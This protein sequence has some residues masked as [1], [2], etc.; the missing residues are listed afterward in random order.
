MKGVSLKGT[1]TKNKL[2][3]FSCVAIVIIVSIVL[4]Y[5][6]NLKFNELAIPIKDI[7]APG[8]GRFSIAVVKMIIDGAWSFLVPFSP[9][10]NAPFHFQMYD[11]PLPFFSNFVYI[12]FL[13][14]FSSDSVVVFNLY[15]ISTYFLNAFTM[16]WVLRR[17][18]VNVYL[19]ISI[20]ILFTFLPF[21]FWRLPHTFYSGYCFIPLWIY[22]LLLLTNKKPLFFKKKVGESKYSFD[23]SKRNII[24]ILVMLISSTWNF[25]YT[26]FFTFLIGFTLLS[27]F[28]YRNSK[29]HILSTLIF[30]SLAVAPFAG[31][32]LPYKAYEIENGKNYQVGQRDPISSETLGL[33]VATLV[34][35]V[36]D[37]RVE[38]LKKLSNNYAYK[39]LL[40]NESN[41]ATLGLFGAIGFAIL[42]FSIFFYSLLP[43]ILSRLS[44][45]NLF[46]L[47]FSTVGGFGVVFAYVITPQIRALNRIS[48]FIAAMSFIAIAVV[49]NKYINKTGN[50]KQA[51]FMA[52]SFF[53]LC[54]GVFDLV[55]T[56]MNLE[57]VDKFK[58]EYLSDKNFIQQIESK[59]DVSSQ[60]I[61]IAQYPYLSFPENPG[62]HTMGNYEQFQGYLHSDKLY[63]SFGAI[64]GRPADIWWK[65]LNEKS[66]EEQI[67]TL[68]Q[69]G[70]SGIMINRNG[71]QDNAKGLENKLI[72]LLGAKPMI[73]ENKIV[74]FFRLYP[75]S[76]EIRFS[77]IAFNSFY[78]WE[79]EPG[80]FRWAGDNANISLF[81]DQGSSKTNNISFTLGTLRDRSMVIKL[82]EEV[83][84][85]FEIKRGESTQHTFNLKLN[86]GQ[87]IL[88]FETMEP[89]RSP[90]GADN[91]KLAFS[92]GEFVYD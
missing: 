16:F 89:A 21:H 63:W 44:Q 81:N 36:I 2:T 5:L 3:I 19:A 7:Y 1:I 25:Y 11:F 86:P 69:A 35:P 22:Y 79:G 9:H 51:V 62:I 58:T 13:S 34:F 37:H 76:N 41:D 31:N 46:V 70:F 47:L 4:Y 77:R 8:D 57:P 85:S 48:M 78:E 55:S 6:Y 66:I 80:K 54:F 88:K 71:Y 90:G 67:Q 45:L 30:L 49:L 84:E 23:W 28:V 24:I 61:S 27:N 15:Y 65:G 72:Q 83:L 82:N 12:K 64:K 56:K 52:L 87:N 59:F 14:I 32:M 40:F 18:R 53:I 60:K 42:I 29:Y 91:R 33:T 73:S 75:T 38:I 20:G 26:F 50:K 74:S 39:S 43:R 10:L 68:Q 17:L 92:V